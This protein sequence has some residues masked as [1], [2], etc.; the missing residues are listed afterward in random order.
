VADRR[1]ERRPK[2]VTRA[3]RIDVADLHLQPQPLEHQRG[4]VDQTG[5]QRQAVRAYRLAA[6]VA[7]K[8]DHRQSPFPRLE[9]LEQPFGCGKGGGALSRRSAGVE[10][11][12]RC[13]HVHRL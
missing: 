11:P 7:R 8:A 6:A 13:G 3:H 4:L 1:Q 5:E 9:R 12:V 2:T 10:G